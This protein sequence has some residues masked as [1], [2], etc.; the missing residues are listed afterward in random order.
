VYAQM[1]MATNDLLHGEYCRWCGRHLCNSF[2]AEVA[3]A[4]EKNGA[5]LFPI[6]C[7]CGGITVIGAGTFVSHF[8]KVAESPNVR[9]VKHP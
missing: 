8:D 2:L 3:G 6:L 5:P 9:K 4:I 7:V 1:T